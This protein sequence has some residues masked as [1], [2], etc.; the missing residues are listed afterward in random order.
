MIEY[1]KYSIIYSKTYGLYI[2]FYSQVTTLFTDHYNIY[3]VPTIVKT[4]LTGSCF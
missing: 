3:I 1:K 4:S 2:L